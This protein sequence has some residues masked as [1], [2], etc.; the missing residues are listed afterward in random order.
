MNRRDF[1]GAHAF[2][3]FPLSISDLGRDY[4]AL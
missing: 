3:H 1:F 2:S 4:Y